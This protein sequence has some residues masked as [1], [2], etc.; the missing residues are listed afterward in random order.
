MAAS[1][2][3]RRP[4]GNCLFGEVAGQLSTCIPSALSM[5][6]ILSAPEVPTAQETPDL[7]RWIDLCCRRTSN[8]R[9]RDKAVAVLMDLASDLH[10]HRRVEATTDT[11]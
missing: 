5:M 10:D 7:L 3:L 9:D 11:V 6:T 8:T 2:L 4:G 1:G